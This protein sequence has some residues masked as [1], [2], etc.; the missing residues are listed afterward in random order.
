[1][2]KGVSSLKSNSDLT[3][4]SSSDDRRQDEAGKLDQGRAYTHTHTY[5]SAETEWEETYTY[6]ILARPISS[7][8]LAHSKH[9][10]GSERR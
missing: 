5:T 1:M 4:V 3:T 8:H 7:C 9:F 6:S 2:L 10:V